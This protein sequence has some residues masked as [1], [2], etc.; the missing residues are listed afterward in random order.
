MPKIE[1][2]NSRFVETKME[3]AANNY[4]KFNL[5]LNQFI[6]VRSCKNTNLNGDLLCL[7][8]SGYFY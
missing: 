6:F 5:S 2:T 8:L 1:P 3:V 4:N 7:T